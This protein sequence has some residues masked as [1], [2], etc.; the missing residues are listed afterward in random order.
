[1]SALVTCEDV[2]V[3]FGLSRALEQVSLEIPAGRIVALVGANGAG[4]TTL[5]KS[6]FGEVRLTSGRI[7]VCDLDPTVSADRRA[8]WQK[9]RFV[10]DTPVLYEEL[11]VREFLAYSARSYGVPEEVVDRMVLDQVLN[12]DLR[13]SQDERIKNLSFGTKRKVHIAT[14]FFSGASGP[15]VLVLDE[16]TVGLDPPSRLILARVLKRY[17]GAGSLESD[18][19]VVISS[20]NLAELSSVAD[21]AVMLHAGKTIASGSIRELSAH[22]T[23]D[24]VYE[25]V[26][27]DTSAEDV[28]DELE[29]CLQVEC[30]PLDDYSLE[31]RCDLPQT[32][33]RVLSLLTEKRIRVREL[34]ERLS[35]LERVFLD[36]LADSE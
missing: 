15:R 11:T 19:S 33:Q 5:F 24:F 14:G 13:E 31:V 6:L 10:G 29:E 20:H 7:R 9:A 36:R 1:M 18:R 3:S 25:L 28:A 8:L 21:H 27:F 22:S 34:K 26:L 12:L 32:V 17:V 16:P 23:E 4:K 2:T 30:M 35:S